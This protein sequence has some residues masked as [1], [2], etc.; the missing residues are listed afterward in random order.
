MN[1]AELTNYQTGKPLHVWR[2]AIGFV[3]EANTDFPNGTVIG[4]MGL[5][6]LVKESVADVMSLLED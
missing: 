5:T 1:T 2:D 4:L 6:V 3:T